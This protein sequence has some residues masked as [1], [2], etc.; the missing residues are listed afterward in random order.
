MDNH[1][2]IFSPMNIYSLEEIFYFIHCIYFPTYLIEQVLEFIAKLFWNSRWL[3]LRELNQLM[4]T[5]S[6]SLLES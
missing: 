5:R 1:Y 6:F 4:N 2:N 3:I